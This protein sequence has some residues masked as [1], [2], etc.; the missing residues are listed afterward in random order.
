MQ[1]DTQYACEDCNGVTRKDVNEIIKY[2]TQKVW[3]RLRI[4]ASGEER[5]DNLTN[6]DSR[7]RG[8]GTAAAPWGSCRC[9]GG[10]AAPDTWSPAAATGS[11]EP[12]WQNVSPNLQG[13]QGGTWCGVWAGKGGGGILPLFTSWVFI[14]GYNG[15]V[16]HSWSITLELSRKKQ[17]QQLLALCLHLPAKTVT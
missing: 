3:Q 16:S 8:P 1:S 7:S 15:S 17:Q 9:T 11:T 14:L 5:P 10:R 4:P 2:S 13:T 12:S 6:P